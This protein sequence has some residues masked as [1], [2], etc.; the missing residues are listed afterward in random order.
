MFHISLL[1]PLMPFL[2]HSFPAV[3]STAY[4]KDNYKYFEIEVTP[5]LTIHRNPLR[6]FRL[7]VSSKNSTVKTPLNLDPHATESIPSLSSNPQT[8]LFGSS[9]FTL[10]NLLLAFNPPPIF[11]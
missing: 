5:N 6:P 8:N 9:G 4:I 2:P 10:F 3:L 11:L 1:D 7:A